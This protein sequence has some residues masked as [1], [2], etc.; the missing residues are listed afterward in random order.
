MSN[1]IDFGTTGD[2]DLTILVDNRTDLIVESTETIKRFTD[3]PLLAEHGF[4]A[5]IDMK[6]IGVRILWD[7]GVTKIALKENMRRL[8]IDPT[9]IRKIA[10]S[11]G[12][13]DH[14]A[15]VSEILSI[16]DIFPAP[17]TWEP[18]ISEDD[19]LASIDSRR[20]PLIAHP[21]AF[22][23]RWGFRDDGSKFGPVLPPPKDQWAALGAKIVLS[24]GPH[25]MES[26]CWTTGTIPRVSFENSGISKKIYYREGDIFHR[27]EIDDDQ[28]IVLNIKHKG[29]VVLSGCAHAGI[30]NTVNYARQISGVNRVLAI[31]GGFHLA[32]AS[33]KDVQQTIDALIDLGPELVVPSHCTGFYA[34]SQIANQMPEAFALGLVGTKYLF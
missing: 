20:I 4:S 31:I 30:I 11:H 6:T 13:N 14:T 22:R 19:I 3:K 5:L 18:D 8:E 27:D 16:M 9:T 34:M 12:H 15:S 33:E 1:T 28:A 24:D 32:R 17:R 7:A 10:L 29:L 25:K 21:A 26:G 23:E 2:V